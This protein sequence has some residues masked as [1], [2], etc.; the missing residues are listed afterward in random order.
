MENRMTTEL[1]R[2]ISTGVVAAD[3]LASMSGL[4]VLQRI[5]DGRF[6]AP[7]IAELL[8]FRWKH[9]NVLLRRERTQ[10]VEGRTDY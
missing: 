6:P 4:E 1:P 10:M 8:G 9:F 5:A 3:V 2:S 7:P